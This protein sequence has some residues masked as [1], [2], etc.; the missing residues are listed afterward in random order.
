MPGCINSN[1]KLNE[2]I[3]LIANG[4]PLNIIET[5]NLSSPLNESF[6]QET[7]Y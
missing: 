1:K 7:W 5:L 4:S 2:S 3:V 6:D